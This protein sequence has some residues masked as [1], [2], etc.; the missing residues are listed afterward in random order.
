MSFYINEFKQHLADVD[1]KVDRPYDEPASRQQM[2]EHRSMGEV[3]AS[4][5]KRPVPQHLMEQMSN[6]RG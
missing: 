2:Q 3:Y 5:P 4:M 1:K 6:Q